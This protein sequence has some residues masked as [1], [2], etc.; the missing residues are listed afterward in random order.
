MIELL[1]DENCHTHFLKMTR[2]G[3]RVD[4]TFNLDADVVCPTDDDFGCCAKAIENIYG[5]Y[6]K[7]KYI[8]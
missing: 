3:S 7:F 8:I 1:D 2:Y 6:C 5:I 4:K